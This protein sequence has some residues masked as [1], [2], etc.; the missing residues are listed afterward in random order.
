M[1]KYEAKPSKPTPTEKQPSAKKTGKSG[2]K[3]YKIWPAVVII[4]FSAAA[5]LTAYILTPPDID[6]GPPPTTGTSGTT[7]PNQNGEPPV[8]NPDS[9]PS[10]DKVAKENFYTFL[11]LGTNDDYNTDTIMLGSVNTETNKAD[12]I[13]IPRDT[14]IDV[15]V[16]F[17][18]INN[19]Y[20]RDGIEETLR[21]VQSITGIYP[22]FYCVVNI[23]AFTKIVDKVGG[24]PFYVPY[25]MY[26]RD[27]DPAMTIDLQKGQQ[28]LTSSKALQLVRYRG[29]SQN[30]YGRIQLQKDFMLATL[31]QVKNKFSL[32]KIPGL[33]EVIGESVKTNMPVKD[34]VWFYMNVI[35]GMNLDEDIV[36]H[37][38]PTNDSVKYKGQDYELLDE[39]GVLE[40]VNKTVNPFTTDITSDML[41]ISRLKD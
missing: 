12:I 35:D 36:F 22:Q 10:D 34:M 19:A 29:T 13:S 9:D 31:K 20:G 26:H 30:D 5:I 25:N 16:K 11:V 18:K 38:L 17:R 32:T 7:V 33:I 23:K 4:L 37:T 21:E 15:N 27:L 41:S 24:V 6:V 8:T 28:T 14:Q 3:R 39:E 2:K 1:G 40:L